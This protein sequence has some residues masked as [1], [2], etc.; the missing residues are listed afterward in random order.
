MRRRERR[1]ECARTGVHT[2][3]CTNTYVQAGTCT[4]THARCIHSN[5][6]AYMQHTHAH[7]RVYTSSKVASLAFCSLHSDLPGVRVTLGMSWSLSGS[8]ASKLRSVAIIC[9]LGLWF[10]SMS[11]AQGKAQDLRFLIKTSYSCFRSSLWCLLF[12]VSMALGRPAGW[13]HD[14]SGPW[15]SRSGAGGDPHDPFDAAER[16][17]CAVHCSRA[18][19]Q[20]LRSQEA[21]SSWGQ[22]GDSNKSAVTRP[23]GGGKCWDGDETGK[24]GGDRW[25]GGTFRAAQSR[26]ASLS[27]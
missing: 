11:H 15:F 23:F 18:L 9:D 2:R 7:T 1:G 26:R 21:W 12:S 22:G 10:G 8:L 19:H 5:A 4:Q 27:R 24:G 16:L 17:L 13:A 3:A 14:P 6:H 20:G 25:G